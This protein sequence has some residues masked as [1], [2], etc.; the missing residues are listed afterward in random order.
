[1]R[2][3]SRTGS[4]FLASVILVMYNFSDSMLVPRRSE[5]STDYPVDY[6]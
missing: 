5:C 2:S 1:M 4:F 3:G 6:K